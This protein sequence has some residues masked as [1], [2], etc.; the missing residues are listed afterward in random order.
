MKK[1]NYLLF[2]IC[3]I[4][5]LQA[6]RFD[7]VS[8][9]G[10]SG[11]ANSFNGA[12]TTVRDS[13][14]NLYII[15]SANGQQ[16]C[17][18]ITANPNPSGSTSTFLYKFNSDGELQFIKVIGQN[19]IPLNLQIGENDNLY[20]LGSLAGNSNLLIGNET[21]VGVENRNYIIKFS[22]DGTLIWTAFNNQSFSGFSA[23]TMLL[24]ANNHIY[25][26]SG[27]TTISKL[28]ID[29]QVVATLTSDNFTPNTANTGINFKGAGILSNGDLVFTAVSR[30]NITYGSTTLT[31][32]FETGTTP[33]LLLRTNQNL[34]VD[35]AIYVEGLGNPQGNNMPITIGNDN[36]IY[37]GVMV[38]T[39]TTA[40]LDTII[41]P[42]PS[43]TNYV[44]AVIKIN[45]LGEKVWIKSLTTSAFVYSILNNP[46]G[47]GVFCGGDFTGSIVLGSTSISETN[48]RSFISKISYDGVFINSFA[49]GGNLVGSTL[50]S[51]AT[52]NNGT[53]YAGGK[54][55]SN[56]TPVFSCV[57]REAHPGFYLG[58]FTELP[59][60]A[61]IPVI[62]ISG[63]ELTASPV[64]SGNIQWF[65][66]GNPISGANSQSLIVNQNGNYTV[67]YTLPDYTF[68]V[69]SSSNF[70]V[71]NLSNAD[72]SSLSNLYK[73]YPNPTS[74]NIFIETA[75][76]NQI[77]S[78][79]IYDSLG[80]KV[81]DTMPINNQIDFSDFS[82]GIF[83]IKILNTDNQLQTFKI[84]K[85]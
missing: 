52:D 18:G 9:G 21:F 82:K 78:V 28:N 40:G 27:N 7:W 53:F 58:K 10:Y 14:G 51:M 43:T 62:T 70:T 37:M 24:F 5:Q 47:S 55:L 72:N 17:Q 79:N 76:T 49:F 65:L 31:S 25:F 84:V 34:L 59:D 45:E 54:L 73:I 36:G 33:I 57:A 42:N 68:C 66:N 19:F 64:F 63:N 6:Q 22:P 20:L 75:E 60:R 41:N 85:Q 16:I 30:G 77:Y 81:A 46:D 61:P 26:Q 12:I 13:Q 4:Y 56:L 3:S 11:V 50:K 74:G 38:N 67:S 1:L 8:T 32:V 35:W 69:S 80:R 29:G 48:G 44:D 71:S 15:D 23:S 2:L 83:I 39:T